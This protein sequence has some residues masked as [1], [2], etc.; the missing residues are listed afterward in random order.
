MAAYDNVALQ[1]PPNPAAMINA[2]SGWARQLYD[3]IGGLPQA[4]YQGQESQYQQRNQNLFQGGL[5]LNAE[6]KPDL[7]A[8]LQALIKAGGAPAAEKVLPMLQRQPFMDAALKEYQTDTGQSQNTG[9]ATSSAAAGPANITG[10]QGQPQTAADNG[11]DTVRTLSAS[12]GGEG[13]DIP[14]SVM[15][16]IARSLGLPNADAG[17]P[18]GMLAAAK[19]RI[20]GFLDRTAGNGIGGKPQANPVSSGGSG[21]EEGNAN[22]LPPSGIGGSSAISPAPT[23]A[24]GSIAGTPARRPLQVTV[25]PQGQAPGQA[26]APFAD[27]FGAAYGGPGNAPGPLAQAGGA[28][29]M[30]PAGADPRSFAEALKKRAEALRRQANTQGIIGIPTKAKEDQAAAMDKQAD[31]ILE[32][33]GKA[34]ELTPE[35]KNVSSGV[36]ERAGQIAADTKYYDSLHR[37]LAGSGMIAA[38]QKQNIDM[39]RQIASAPSFTPGAGTDLWRTYQRS[40]AQLGI[41]PQG[42]APREIFDQV[43]ARILADQFSGM[44]SLASETGEQGARVF[45]SM[46]DIEEKANITPEDSLAGI[47]AKIDLLDKT[48]DMMI[49]WANKADDYKLRHG[50]LDAGFDKELRTDIARARVQDVVPKGGASQGAPIGAPPVGHVQDGWQF[51]GGNH[52]DPKNW[53]RVRPEDRS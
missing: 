10:G 18:E 42:A 24:S 1:G 36:T 35:Q 53:R 51:Q 29:N 22:H 31:A 37:G 4:Y 30:V 43:A 46:L 32:Q 3:M 21:D 13:R 7:Y 49:K 19:T 16:R 39:L 8:T 44:R 6:G 2:G 40:L 5:P 52:R 12:I 23:S 9:P 17:I 27:R 38:Q 50:R 47:K 26:P 14:G 48:G 45:K 28:A 41:N 15:D 25:G 11:A 20:S 33:L 34:G